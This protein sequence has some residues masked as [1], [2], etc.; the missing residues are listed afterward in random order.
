MWL[1][2]GIGGTG[3]H[4]GGLGTSAGSGLLRSHAAHA[5]REL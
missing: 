4:P 5:P 3:R 1:E 2:Y